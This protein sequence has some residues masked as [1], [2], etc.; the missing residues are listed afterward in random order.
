MCMHVAPEILQGAPY[1]H[2]VD[3]WALGVLACRMYT[4]RYPN[5]GQAAGRLL[6]ASVD[7]IAPEGRDLLRRLLQPAPN[8]RLR[9]LLQLQRIALYQHYRWEDV[10]TL[11]ISPV[12]L[13]DDECLNDEESEEDAETFPGF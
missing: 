12:E 8:D 5:A 10:R 7:R 2:A 6:P 4:G 11:Q 9:S 3:W 13:F 1:G